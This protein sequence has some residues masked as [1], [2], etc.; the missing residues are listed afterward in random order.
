MDDSISVRLSGYSH[1]GEES[2]AMDYSFEGKTVVIT[3]GAR[4]Q[5]RS[6]A[7]AFAN[8]GALRYQRETLQSPL[9]TED[10]LANTRKMLQDIDSENMVVDVDVSSE[11]EVWV[12][13]SMVL[14]KYGAVNVLINNAGV[15]SIYPYSEISRDVWMDL[16]D[17]N[18]FGTFWCCKHFAPIMAKSGGG[19]IVNIASLG[20]LRGAAQ[21]AH[22]AASKAGIIALSRNLAVE[23]GP[24][25]IRVNAICPSLGNSEGARALTEVLGGA[26]FGPMYALPAV[27]SLQP[28][29]VTGCVLWLASE[30]GRHITGIVQILDAG[31]WL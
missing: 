15:V 6:H 7:M 22:Y 27:A 9:S 30:S 18:L 20:G 16:L 12:A 28:S 21:Q 25:S 29:D 4:G 8:L 26:D 17:V 14:T 23:L 19:A 3:R 5:G 10:D 24:F 13:A 11:D 31:S 1:L 2:D